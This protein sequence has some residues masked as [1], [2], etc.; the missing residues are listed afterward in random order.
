[1]ALRALIWSRQM[2]VSATRTVL[3]R[4]L[5]VPNGTGYQGRVR[6]ERPEKACFS[7]VG[8]RVGGGTARSYYCFL[9][10]AS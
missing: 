8:C 10:T 4:P 1:M 9:R 2:V 7:R 6:E 3:A 5:P